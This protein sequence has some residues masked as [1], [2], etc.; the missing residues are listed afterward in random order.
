MINIQFCKAE[1][2]DRQIHFL[3]IVTLAKSEL[4]YSDSMLQHEC[5]IIRVTISEVR[6]LKI[7]WFMLEH[8]FMDVFVS[9]W[10]S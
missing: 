8:C 1:T 3:H 4:F 2:L 5:R 6:K 9:P 10:L 7:T